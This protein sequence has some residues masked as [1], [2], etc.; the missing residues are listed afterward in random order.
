MPLLEVRNLKVSVE[1]DGNEILHGLSLTVNRGEVHAIMGPNGSGKSTLSHVLAGKPGYEVT[2]GEVL[3]EGE[4]IFDLGAQGVEHVVAGEQARA[5][6]GEVYFSVVDGH[7]TALGALGGFA[8][9]LSYGSAEYVM[10]GYTWIEV[11]PVARITLTG[12]TRPGVFA[13]DVYEYVLGQIGPN[14]DVL[15]DLR[16]PT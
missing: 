1:E 4:N 11:P 6:P 14:G 10:T 15:R 9:A 16:S 5:L 12:R 13:R 3:F 8:V 2:A 7:T